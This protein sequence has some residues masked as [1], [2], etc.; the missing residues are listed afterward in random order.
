MT[1][2]TETVAGLRAL[3]DFLEDHPE[4]PVDGVVAHPVLALLTDRD[5]GEEID[6]IAF[7]LGETPRMYGGSYTVSRDFGGG[8]IYRAF[9]VASTSMEQ[10]LRDISYHGSVTAP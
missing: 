9:K 5:A 3:A 6:R 8:V 2:T 1:N 4:L 7:I 10:Y